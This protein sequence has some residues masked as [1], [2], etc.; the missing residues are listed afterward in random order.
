MSE[1]TDPTGAG[2]KKPRR[3]VL[4][5]SGEA[6]R[7]DG[8]QDNISPEIVGKM[9][10]QIVEALK[11]GVQIAIVVG[12]GNFWRGISASNRGMERA[13]ADYM[14][15]LATV[16]NSLALQSMLE[17][18]GVE[19]RVQTAIEMK[20]VAEPF[21]RRVAIGHLEKGRVV[22]FGA[23]TGNPFFSTD[24]TA[25]LRA[26]E[27]N[28]DVILK[29][30]KVDG[31]YDSDPAKNPDAVRFDDIS[32]HEAISRRLKVMDSTAFSLCMD[33]NKPIMVFDMNEPGNLKR[34]LL[35]AD[36]GTLVHAG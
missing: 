35:G 18:M 3:V 30:T 20:N 19:V 12:G 13:T 16:M 26:S 33:N 31:V 25:A 34:A 7:E 15:M 32:F 9:A 10:S 23:G 2:H 29:A 5:L 22:I 17:E 28:A 21:I 8:S 4:K 27:I 6:L 11:E 14:G 36:I 1:S 24:T